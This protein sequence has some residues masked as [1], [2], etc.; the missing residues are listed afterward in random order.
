MTVEVDGRPLYQWPV[1]TGKGAQYDT[2]NGKFKAFRMERDHFSKEWDDAPM[3][4]SIFFTQ[5]GHAIHGSFDVKRLGTPASHGCVR[6]APPNAKTL[7]ELVEREG[8]L[9][10]TV[11]LTGVAPSGAPLWRGGARR[12]QTIS[13]ESMSSSRRRSSARATARTSRSTAIRNTPSRSTCSRSTPSPSNTGS[14]N[15]SRSANRRRC[16][17]GY[18]LSRSLQ[19]AGLPAARPR[20]LFP[21]DSHARRAGPESLSKG[22]LRV[23]AIALQIW[24]PGA[25]WLADMTRLGQCG[26]RGDGRAACGCHRIAS[27]A[28]PRAQDPRSISRRRRRPPRVRSS[29]CAK[30]PM[31]NAAFGLEPRDRG[32][33]RADALV[34]GAPG[35]RAGPTPLPAP[36]SAMSSPGTAFR[37]PAGQIR[38]FGN[39]QFV[40]GFTN[41][42]S[43]PACETRTPQLRQVQA[44]ATATRCSP[45]ARGFRSIPCPANAISPACAR[46]R[47]AVVATENG[48]P[49]G[50][51]HHATAD[52]RDCR[53]H[54]LTIL[55]TQRSALTGATLVHFRIDGNRAA[56]DV[57]RAMEA[58]RIVSQPNYVYVIGQGARGRDRGSRDPQ[59]VANKLRLASTQDRDWQGRDSR[60]HRQRI[61]QQHP[62][63]RR[64]LPSGSTRWANRI[65]RICTAPAWRARSSRKAPAG[66]GTRRADARVH[67]FSTG[68]TQQSPQATTQSI[69]AGPRL[70]DVERRHASINMSFAGPTIRSSRSR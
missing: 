18:V 54:N 27:S 38:A 61:D 70:G 32:A 53:Q 39:N 47:D 63:L 59:Y 57:V 22:R 41:P 31:G 69:I 35:T 50:R 4:H 20:S 36:A 56:R 43:E 10:T 19:R 5:K 25:P 33:A 21:F 64:A 7:F 68:G 65:G 52:R 12:L 6:L 26:R 29:R 13:T 24:R 15:T 46:H 28:S 23:A 45:C 2:P 40:A 66:C 44:L 17:A 62:N 3:P 34:G 9:N 30:G 67:A 37:Q 55:A 42:R 48:L 16:R 14:R 58:E 8:V 60:R 11:V 49:V 1:S 51:R